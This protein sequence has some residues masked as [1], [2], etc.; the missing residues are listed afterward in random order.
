MSWVSELCRVKTSVKEC[1]LVFCSFGVSVSVVHR[2]KFLF[3]GLLISYS[4][5]LGLDW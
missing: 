1:I 3:F 4:S 5:G 2:K